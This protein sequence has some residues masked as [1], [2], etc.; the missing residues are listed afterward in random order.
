MN[1]PG[2]ST[3]L[4]TALLAG[5]AA[6]AV[7]LIAG[8]GHSGS[9]TT[10]VQQEPLTSQDALAADTHSAPGPTG[11]TPAEI[12]KL[13]APG[14]VYI[15]SDVVQ[16]TQSPFDLFPQQEQGTA[17]GSG[18]VVNRDGDILTNAH[19]IDGA[20]KITVQFGNSNAVTATVVGKDPSNDLALLRVP[21]TGITLD[22]LPLGNSNTVQ[23][24]DPALAIGNP[25]GLDRTL[26]TGVISA[27]Q[28]DITAPNGFSIDNVIQT[29]APINPG[30]SGGPLLNANGQVIGINSQIET[31]GNG[32][33]SVGV[34]FAIPID[35]AKAEL[36][37]LENGEQIKQGYLG[38]QTVSIDSSLAGLNLPVNYGSLVQSVEAGSPAAKAG[39]QAGNVTATVDGNPIELGGDI[40]VSVDGQTVP[41]SNILGALIESKKPGDS[42]TLGIIRDGKHI[43]VRVTLVQR[44]ASVNNPD[45]PQDG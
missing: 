12:Y 22:P 27:L 5:G 32:D 26:T 28:R 35:T 44:P 1:G 6:A 41:N 31:G 4:L 17:T 19:V 15:T 40:I 21:T 25:F 7:L 24:G 16:Q 13:D 23:V 18:F 34:G 8:V 38:L 43:N 14:V 11:L 39:I 29:D 30:N 42:V 20:Y 10:V 37:E 3:H 9:T 45:T 33:A 36:P 2:R